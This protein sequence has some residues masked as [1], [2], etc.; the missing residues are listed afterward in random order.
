MRAIE[1][2]TTISRQG[3]IDLP[4]DCRERSAALPGSSCCWMR[5]R[6]PIRTSGGNGSASRWKGWPPP[7]RS[8]T[9]STP[10]PGNVS[11]GRTALCRDGRSE[12]AGRQQQPDFGRFPTESS[13]AAMADP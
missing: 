3:H 8:P 4:E 1:L 12:H 11:N 5:C 10:A 2:E 13:V 9:S 6:R 7:A